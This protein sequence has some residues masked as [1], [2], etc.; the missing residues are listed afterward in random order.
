M[1][2]ELRKRNWCN[3]RLWAVGS[4]GWC[5]WDR[6]WGRS[7]RSWC[8]GRGRV[9]GCWCRRGIGACLGVDGLSGI[10]NISDVS[11]IPVDAVRHSLDAAVGKGNVVRALD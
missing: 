5:N 3:N 1:V 9:I 10:G 4:W 7:V 8:W 6:C 11:A 2:G